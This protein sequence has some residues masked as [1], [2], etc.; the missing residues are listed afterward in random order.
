MNFPLKPPYFL[1]IS[2]IVMALIFHWVAAASSAPRLHHRVPGHE[3]HGSPWNRLSLG[4]WSKCTKWPPVALIGMQFQSFTKLPQFRPWRDKMDKD[5]L[6]SEQTLLE[7][8]NCWFEIMIPVQSLG[9]TTGL[10]ISWAMS[11][12]DGTIPQVMLELYPYS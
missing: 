10:S 3:I 4:R 6:P 8:D 7:G 5:S 12:N 2:H 1:G 9:T 11:K